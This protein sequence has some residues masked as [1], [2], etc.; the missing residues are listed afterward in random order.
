MKALFQLKLL[1][2]TSPPISPHTTLFRCANF[3]RPHIFIESQAVDD[4]IGRNFNDA[5]AGRLQQGVVMR[6]HD[7]VAFEVT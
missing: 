3:V 5:L 6:S 4:A 2:K 7:Q 1:I